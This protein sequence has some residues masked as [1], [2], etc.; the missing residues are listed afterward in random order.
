MDK[1]ISPA[2]SENWGTSTSTN[3]GAYDSDSNNSFN[4]DYQ[5]TFIIVTSPETNT[6]YDSD[7]TK[8]VRFSWVTSLDLEILS[9]GFVYKPSDFGNTTQQFEALTG[10]S[11]LLFRIVN[12]ITGEVVHTFSSQ[13][14]WGLEKVEFPEYIWNVSDIDD[15]NGSYYIEARYTAYESVEFEND[16]Y[17]CTLDDVYTEVL[18]GPDYLNQYDLNGNICL[19]D[20]PVEDNPPPYILYDEP[21]YLS[22][23]VGCISV[24]TI[25]TNTDYLLTPITILSDRVYFSIQNKSELQGCTDTSS[26]VQ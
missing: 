18:C 6:I 1:W 23:I 25:I 20:E 5:K 3:I 15:L 13:M 17:Y 21:F 19:S 12:D 14:F 4:D 7:E 26:S 22:G 10:D 16:E 24:G 11:F 2:V 8:S 9:N